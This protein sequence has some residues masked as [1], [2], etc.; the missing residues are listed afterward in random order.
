[1]A[2]FVPQ[3]DWACIVVSVPDLTEGEKFG[4]YVGDA[5]LADATAGSGLN[6]GGQRRHR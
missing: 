4:L 3:K 1:M 2:A 5:L 6:G